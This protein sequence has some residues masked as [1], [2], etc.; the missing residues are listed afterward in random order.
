M[1]FIVLSICS[2]IN[3]HRILHV[4]HTFRITNV[5][6]LINQKK[7]LH[8]MAFKYF[9]PFYYYIIIN[10]SIMSTLNEKGMQ[11]NPFFFSSS[12]LFQL[13]VLLFHR[14]VFFPFIPNYPHNRTVDT[15][16]DIFSNNVAS[17]TKR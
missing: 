14:A 9:F 5:Y 4:L 13:F 11:K 6:F 2:R 3:F 1:S 15:E 12:V 10:K 8:E 16:E 17:D 7:I